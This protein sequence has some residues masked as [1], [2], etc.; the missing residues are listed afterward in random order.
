MQD[1]VASTALTGVNPKT[2]GFHR[3]KSNCVYLPIRV[4]FTLLTRCSSSPFDATAH[5]S[6][7]QLKA[8]WIITER[9]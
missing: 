7:V 2:V 6:S 9:D 8:L 4:P 1:S 3:K 5:T